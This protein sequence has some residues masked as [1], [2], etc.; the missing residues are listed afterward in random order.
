MLVIIVKG[1]SIAQIHNSCS[2]Q[3]QNVHAHFLFNRINKLLR[4]GRRF[5]TRLGSLPGEGKF[6]SSRF[7]FS[8]ILFFST[9]VLARHNHKMFMPIFSFNRINKLLRAGRRFETRLGSLPGED[10]QRY[11]NILKIFYQL[12]FPEVHLYEEA[13][14]IFPSRA[15]YKF[16]LRRSVEE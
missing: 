7:R 10:I 11:E 12:H 1:I 8:K 14:L 16:S 13:E 6:N 15:P 3:P 9:L 4:A 2:T 5:E